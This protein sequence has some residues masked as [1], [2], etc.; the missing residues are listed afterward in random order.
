MIL[1]YQ[2]KTAA[3]TAAVFYFSIYYELEKVV[4]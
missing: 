3:K 1:E 2:Q 4:F